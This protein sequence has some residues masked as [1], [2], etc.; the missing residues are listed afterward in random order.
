MSLH[1]AFCLVRSRLG[2]LVL[3]VGKR[4]KKSEE[5][6]SKIYAVKVPFLFNLK[7]R[8]SEIVIVSGST[9]R[10]P[11]STNS[12]HTRLRR[13]SFGAAPNL[14]KDIVAPSCTEKISYYY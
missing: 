7:M 1:L 3:T 12:D 10:S 9:Y 2:Y 5:G 8:A 13:P 4:L 11:V 6:I 14:P